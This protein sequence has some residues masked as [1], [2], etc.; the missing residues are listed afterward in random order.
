MLLHHLS[1]LSFKLGGI[2]M[3]ALELAGKSGVYGAHTNRRMIDSG[4]ISLESLRD[5]ACCA[6]GDCDFNRRE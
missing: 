5:A 3:Q 1:L 2:S 4:C 6:S